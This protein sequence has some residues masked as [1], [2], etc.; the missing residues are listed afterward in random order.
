MTRYSSV[1]AKEPAFTSV[2]SSV[3]GGAANFA[4]MESLAALQLQPTIGWRHKGRNCTGRRREPGARTSKM[5]TWSNSSRLVCDSHAREFSAA[6]LEKWVVRLWIGVIVL[7]WNR[8]K[9]TL[10]CLQTPDELQYAR[11]LCDRCRFWRDIRSGRLQP[12]RSP[13]AG[14]SRCAM[15]CPVISVA[16]SPPFWASPRR[17]QRARTFRDL[18][19]RFAQP[20]GWA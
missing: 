12:T 9:A 19:A 8:W 14:M 10:T 18:G 2:P 4:D 11:R 17:R 13:F 1:S 6:H 3:S 16:S 15:Q 5:D 7:N 20:H